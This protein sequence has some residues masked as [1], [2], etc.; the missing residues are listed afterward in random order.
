ME[1]LTELNQQKIILLN[2]STTQTEM[3]KKSFEILKNLFFERKESFLVS[4]L[5]K[6]KD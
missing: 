4:L 1:G 6:G 5:Q 3:K 2:F